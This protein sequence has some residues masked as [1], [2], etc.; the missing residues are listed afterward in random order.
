MYFSLSRPNKFYFD[1]SQ[2]EDYF[3]ATYILSFFCV[4]LIKIK[5]VGD[6]NAGRHYTCF[7]QLILLHD[8]LYDHFS[9]CCTHVHHLK[10]NVYEIGSMTII[11]Q[12]QT[13]HHMQDHPLLHA[14]GATIKIFYKLRIG[15]ELFYGKRYTRVIKRNNY[16]KKGDIF[17]FGKV[18]FCTWQRL[19]VTSNVHDSIPKVQECSLYDVINICDVCEKCVCI[20]RLIMIICM[21]ISM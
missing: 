18:F 21:S 4:E 13:P 6:I 11:N 9:L 7:V 1:T 14:D 12:Y 15:C 3:C 17:Y 20:Q 10:E 16:Y 19:V 8:G 5:E 2:W